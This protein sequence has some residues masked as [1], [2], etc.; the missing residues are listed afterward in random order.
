[1][2]WWDKRA[3]KF[4]YENKNFTHEMI[5]YLKLMLTLILKLLVVSFNIVS[6]SW[7]L[8]VIFIYITCW[9]E[10]WFSYELIKLV[11]QN[12]TYNLSGILCSIT[13]FMY[14]II[15]YMDVPMKFIRRYWPVCT[16][17]QV[18]STPHGTEILADPC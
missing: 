10:F 1:M 8:W 12:P 14:V 2:K 13:W 17:A 3:L 16:A 18:L 9:L 4:I 6:D 7:I 5:I 15:I 11:Y